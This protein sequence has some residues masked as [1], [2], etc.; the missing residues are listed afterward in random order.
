MDSKLNSKESEQRKS[1]ELE[2]EEEPG[3]W[4]S[5]KV[6]TAVSWA[7]LAAYTGRRTGG[8]SSRAFE[9]VI[10]GFGHFW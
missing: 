5:S 3:G 7:G 2:E 6:R 4:I 9:V 1:G 8:C 10:R